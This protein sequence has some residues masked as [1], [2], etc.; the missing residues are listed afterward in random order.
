MIRMG[1]KKKKSYVMPTEE[2]KEQLRTGVK[3]IKE[4]YDKITKAEEDINDWKEKIKDKGKELFKIYHANKDRL[5]KRFLSKYGLVSVRRGLGTVKT[6]KGFAEKIIDVLEDLHKE[7]LIRRILSIV[8]K[9]PKDKIGKICTSVETIFKNEGI[10]EYSIDIKSELNKDKIQKNPKSI[11][12]VAQLKIER[13]KIFSVR[14][15]G[16]E[17][18]PKDLKKEF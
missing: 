7:F 4:F 8:F 13:K 11:K 16:F 12:D 5:P 15:V 18:V 1:K 3:E 17:K 2:A 9:A 14:P 10:K 6:L